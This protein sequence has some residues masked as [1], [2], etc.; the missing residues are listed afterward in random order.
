[1][2]VRF[3][4]VITTSSGLLSRTADRPRVDVEAARTS[5]RGKEDLDAYLVNMV[6]VKE[7]DLQGACVKY[8]LSYV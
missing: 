2:A 6:V 8:Q 1:M 3:A 7:E 4:Y 5:L